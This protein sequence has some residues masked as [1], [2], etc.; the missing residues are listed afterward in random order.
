MREAEIA[1]VRA[2]GDPAHRHFLFEPSMS[3]Q[4]V[5]RVDLENDFRQ[6]LTREELRLQYQ[7]LVDLRRACSAS[8]PSPL[9]APDTDSCRRWP[10]SPWPRR[11]A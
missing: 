4:T 9:A 10:S 6:A 2:K 8:R 1:M 3:D 5:E 11:P 7:P